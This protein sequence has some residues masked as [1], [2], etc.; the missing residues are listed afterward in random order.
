MGGGEIKETEAKIERGGP[1]RGLI[2]YFARV[3]LLSVNTPGDYA[4]KRIG[5]PPLSFFAGVVAALQVIIIRHEKVVGRP[6]PFVCA[7]YR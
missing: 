4:F 7:S 6:H 1:H 5:F 3:V 2:G